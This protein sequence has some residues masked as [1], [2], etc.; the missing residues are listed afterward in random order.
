MTEKGKGN[1]RVKA[2]AK[3]EGVSKRD[4]GA[5]G[6][7]QAIGGVALLF[8]GSLV[9]LLFPDI[10]ELTCRNGACSWDQSMHTAV[11]LFLGIGGTVGAGV[12]LLGIGLYRIL[13]KG[14]L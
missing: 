11:G 13:R 7:V 4:T 9:Y 3:R 1:P 8:S 14:G 12:I 5:P 10:V 2:E 6:V